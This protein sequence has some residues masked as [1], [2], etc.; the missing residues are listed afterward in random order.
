VLEMVRAGLADEFYDQIER[1]LVAFRDPAEYGR[2]P[3]ENSSFLVSSGFDIDPR[4]H[5]RGCVARLSGS[6]VEFLHLWTH[7]FLGANPFVLEEGRLLFRPAPVLSK[8]FFSTSEQCVTPFDFE[9]TLPADSA[10]CALLGGTLLVYINPTRQDTYGDAAVSPC[11]YLL[12][13][14]DGGIQTVEGPHLEGQVAEALRQGQFRRVDV[15]LV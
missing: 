11:R 7:L 12:H 1:L 2:N 4:Q 10:A 8:S 14:R 3:V 15:V 6:T 13:G 9:E 5:G